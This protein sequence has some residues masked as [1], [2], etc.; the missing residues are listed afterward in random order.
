MFVDEKGKPVNLLKELEDV[1]DELKEIYG[2][3]D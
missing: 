3:I 1:Q 2:Q